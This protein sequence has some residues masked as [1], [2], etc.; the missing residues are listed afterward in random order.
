MCIG[1]P[2]KVASV[3]EN[4]LTAMVQSRDEEQQVN[5]LMLQEE[6][7]R[8]DYLIVQVG[9]FAVE[10]M[11]PEEAEKALALIGALEKGDY[12]RAKELY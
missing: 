2:V 7:N 4:G 12:T 9:G 6:V 11:G 3:S 8:G 5:L 1:V 10:K